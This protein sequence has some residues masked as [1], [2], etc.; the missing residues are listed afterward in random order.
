MEIHQVVQ[1]L[2]YGDAVSNNAIA[3]R[4]I[5]REMGYRS[6]I[7]ARWYDPRVSK[8]I[9]PLN[10]Y[11]GNAANIIF[12]H[13]PLAGG[14]VTEFVKSL[15][16]KKV[17][18]YHNITPPEFFYKFEKT[19][20][21]K[22]AEGLQEIKGLAG[23]FDMALGVSEFNRQALIDYG[24]ENTD[25]LPIF[26]DLDKFDLADEKKPE[27]VKKN[28][29][30][31]FLFVGRLAP[32]K[33]DE[34]IIKSFFC[35]N[36]FINENS[37]LYLVGSKQIR[38]YTSHLELL[39]KSL[40][41]DDSV[42]FTGSVKDAELKCYYK[43]ADIFL[44]MSEHEGFCVPLLEAMHFQIPIVAY[45]STGIPHTLGSSGLIVNEKDYIRIA[46]LINIVLQDKQLKEK[47]QAKQEKRL[48]EFD[49]DMIAESLFS[50][51]DNVYSATPIDS[52]S[53]A[54]K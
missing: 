35:Y 9:R 46:E 15:P 18:I 53:S 42:I 39:V 25:I 24:F 14:E 22:C 6:D 36:R 45:R 32:N 44:C 38:T 34:D 30:V 11:K 54:G 50:I 17:L 33:C 43:H 51:I 16:D 13:F 31:N 5:L 23:H 2:S 49:R 4:G 52:R 21:L 28:G 19:S 40:G 29:D 37:K 3:L 41:L 47:I 12:Y 10:K 8:Y 7:Y 20:A 27:S 1:A 48:K 26:L